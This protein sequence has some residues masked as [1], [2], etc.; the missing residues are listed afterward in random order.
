MVAAFYL[1]S[2]DLAIWTQL[3]TCREILRSSCLLCPLCLSSSSRNIGAGNFGVP[4]YITGDASTA[5]TF[6][7]DNVAVV[8]WK[9]FLTGLAIRE[10]TM[11]ELAAS[12]A[13]FK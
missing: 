1:L 3:R 6:P 11:L 4:H 9:A 2:S 8:I 5:L 7:T 13:G 12:K 10:A